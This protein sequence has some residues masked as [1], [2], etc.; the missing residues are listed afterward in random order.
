MVSV[1]QQVRREEVYNGA[2][3]DIKD[4]DKDIRKCVRKWIL[5]NKNHHKVVMMK[6]FYDRIQ[7]IRRSEDKYTKTLKEY[8]IYMMLNGHLADNWFVT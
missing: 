1:L 2:T 5:R 6:E 7:E 3:P 4:M 8:W